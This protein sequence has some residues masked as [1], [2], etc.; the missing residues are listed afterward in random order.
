MAVHDDLGARCETELAGHLLRA[1][2]LQPVDVEVSRAW[3]VALPRVARVAERAVVLVLR[4]HVDDRDL[5][6]APRELVDEDVL[7]HSDRTI[8]ASAATEGLR[9]SSS[10]QA[11]SRSGSFTPSMSL[12]RSTHGT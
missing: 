9:E 5:T 4:A 11:S 10:T 7:G 12:A 6:E 1:Q 8:S 2:G 3:D